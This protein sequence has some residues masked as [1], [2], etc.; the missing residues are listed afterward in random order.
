MAGEKRCPQI[1]FCITEPADLSSLAGAKVL[2]L[3]AQIEAVG[4]YLNA[5]ESA[6]VRL[7]LNHRALHVL[8]RVNLEALWTAISRIKGT[9][10]KGRL[11]LGVIQLRLYLQNWFLLNRK[12]GVLK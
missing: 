4:T 12:D 9:I 2:S 8:F 1:V 10:I 7:F 11:I 6:V 5:T 3:L